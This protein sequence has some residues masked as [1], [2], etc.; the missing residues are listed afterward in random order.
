ML[1]HLIDEA[2]RM[3][4]VYHTLQEL[5]RIIPDVWPQ[6]YH[7]RPF[8]ETLVH[9]PNIRLSR[10]YWGSQCDERFDP[11]MGWQRLIFAYEGRLGWHCNNTFHVLPVR[12]VEVPTKKILALQPSMSLI[13][14][15][16][17]SIY[18]AQDTEVL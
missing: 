13:L 4:R 9:E 14:H 11:R 5:P 7:Y 10:W 3:G 6:I 1:H 8:M 15:F 16:N 17:S 18:P 2:L 12:V